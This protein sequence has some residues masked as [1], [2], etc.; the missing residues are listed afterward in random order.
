MVGLLRGSLLYDALVDRDYAVSSMDDQIREEADIESI[1]YLDLVTSLHSNMNYDGPNKEYTNKYL[2]SIGACIRYIHIVDRYMDPSKWIET[3]ISSSDY[4]E[5][6]MS[7]SMK[8]YLLY[9]GFNPEWVSYYIDP[10][11]HIERPPSYIL[12]HP[13]LFLLSRGDRCFINQA[14]RVVTNHGS[15]V[16]PKL[17]SEISTMRGVPIY[18]VEDI[19]QHRVSS[20]TREWESERSVICLFNRDIF[21]ITPGNIGSMMT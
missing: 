17:V 1:D 2:T 16:T 6:P 15:D 21:D 12:R 4:E 18:E 13:L 3:C 11:E 5:R 7:T 14:R 9:R 10:D 20:P 19:I 8:R